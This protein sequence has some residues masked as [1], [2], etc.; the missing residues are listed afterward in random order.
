MVH[1]R[2]QGI[3]L[4]Y[5]TPKLLYIAHKKMSYLITTYLDHLKAILSFPRNILSDQNF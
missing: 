2:Y 5:F 4:L 3:D 1:D